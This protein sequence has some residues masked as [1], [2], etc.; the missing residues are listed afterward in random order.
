MASIKKVNLTSVSAFCED[1]Y[2]F[3]FTLGSDKQPRSII[4]DYEVATATQSLLAAFESYLK[5]TYGR[6]IRVD[7]TAYE[8]CPAF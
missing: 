1:T 7:W 6:H 2:Q 8:Y 5:A 3:V 4:L